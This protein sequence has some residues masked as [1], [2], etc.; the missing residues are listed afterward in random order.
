MLKGRVAFAIG[1]VAAA[2]ALVLGF[3]SAPA[4]ARTMQF[5][6]V[7]IVGTSPAAV[8][9]GQTYTISFQLMRG[10]DAR[11]IAGV[12]CYA[13]AGGRRAQLVDQGT[14]GTVGHCTWTIPRRAAGLTFDGIIS[15]QADSGTWWNRG[16]DLPV[17]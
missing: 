16:F 14:D 11:H 1:V 10:D 8:T 3:S 12:G 15:A 17:S 7:V 13:I 4:S 9:A 6:E 2:F 5:Q